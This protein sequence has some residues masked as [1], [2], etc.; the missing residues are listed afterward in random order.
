MVLMSIFFF[1]FKS[2]KLKKVKTPQVLQASQAYIV[3]TAR[4]VALRIACIMLEIMSMLNLQR[5]IY[6]H[7]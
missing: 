1:F 5:P 2:K 7:I 6:S 3:H 4:T